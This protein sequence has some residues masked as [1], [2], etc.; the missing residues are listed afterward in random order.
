MPNL[1]A[2]LEDDT[3]IEGKQAFAKAWQER[4]KQIFEQAEHPELVVF[5]E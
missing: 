3:P 5:K 4:V 2:S 1:L